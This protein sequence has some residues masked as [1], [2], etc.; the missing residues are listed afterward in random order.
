MARTAAGELQK[1]V[2]Q[3]ESEAAIV[4][5]LADRGLFAVA[6]TEV[7]DA[8]PLLGGSRRVRLRD[9][10]T[11]FRQLADLLRVGVPVLRSLDTLA[12]ACSS[13]PLAEVIR[14]LREKISQGETLAE[15]V[16]EHPK[17]FTSLHKAMILAGEEAG[18]LEGVLENLAE[19]IERQDELRAKV[20]GMLIYPVVLLGI[21]GLLMLGI[22]IFLVPMFRDFFGEMVLPMPTQVLFAASAML[23]DHSMLLLAGL[24][25]FVAGVW[26]FGRSETGHRYKEH[27]RL[28][29]PLVGK[30]N[31]AVS[32]ARFC[33]I[34][35]TMLHNGVPILRALDISKGATGSETLEAGIEEA[36]ASV[37]AGEALAEPL[38]ATGGFTPDVIEMIAVAEESNQMDTVLVRIADTVEKRANQMV[39][40]AVRLMEPLILVFL[41]GMIGFVAVGLLYPIFMLSQQI[42]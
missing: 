37:R 32:M 15:A 1:G 10:G 17:V 11:V 29:L 28:T 7:Q 31:R 3:G 41:A 16:G 25:L 34:L 12:K 20:R 23:V 13:P 14:D 24:V 33:R 36:A 40:T 21:G 27:L 8:K 19:F 2:M 5:T 30:L 18:F 4:R 9:V 6:V 35:G 26:A 38:R 22:L 42:A 39:D